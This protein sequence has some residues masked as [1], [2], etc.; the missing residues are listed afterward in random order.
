MSLDKLK[1][2]YIIPEG[3][4]DFHAD[5][6]YI[7]V[8]PTGFFN[9]HFFSERRPIPQETEITLPGDNTPAKELNAKYGCDI[10][11]SIQTS[12]ALDLEATIAIRDLLNNL[13]NNTV[14]AQ[15]A[16]DGDL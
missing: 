12:V 13:I 3:L 9:L 7:T 2:K 14:T 10:V 8:T 1:I 15:E 5:G 4:K 16:T 6:A 11:R